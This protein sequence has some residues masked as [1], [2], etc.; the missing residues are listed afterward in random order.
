MIFI[1]AANL[2]SA[3][4]ICPNNFQLLQSKAK[5]TYSV[6]DTAYIDLEFLT[7]QFSQTDSFTLVIQNTEH[8]F[9]V[10]ERAGKIPNYYYAP[11]NRIYPLI[12]TP[13]M[14][15]GSYDVFCSNRSMSFRQKINIVGNP[16]AIDLA[17]LS[18]VDAG[19]FTIYTATGELYTTFEGYTLP[20]D[21]PTGLWLYNF[22][23]KKGRAR[24]KFLRE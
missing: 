16:A 18:P 11:K 17:T 23:N 24:G 2:V 6:G 4:M 22:E 10:K 1:S 13:A 14:V 12:I 5:K 20:I 8:S 3:T 15:D 7:T 9:S 21:L 19:T